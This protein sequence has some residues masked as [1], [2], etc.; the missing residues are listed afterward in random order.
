MQVV[1]GY[2]FDITCRDP[3]T[4]EY[5]DV[6]KPHLREK[7]LRMVREQTPLWIIGSPMCTAWSTW[8]T[9]NAKRRLVDQA[10]LKRL[11]VQARVHLDFVC[12]IY[13]EQLDGGRFFLHEHPAFATSWQEETI[14][15]IA[16]HDDVQ[17]VHA[18]QCQHN[19]EVQ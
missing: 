11:K 12:R 10:K 19:S 4:G 5:W 3:E 16:E 2:A 13:P 7:A 8:Q 6:D 14:R 18:D 1:P 9:L 17:T 15:N